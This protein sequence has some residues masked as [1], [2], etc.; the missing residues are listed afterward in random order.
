VLVIEPAFG[1]QQQFVS[2][3]RIQFL[4]LDLGNQSLG[5]SAR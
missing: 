1:G 5:R 2:D 4:S 3:S